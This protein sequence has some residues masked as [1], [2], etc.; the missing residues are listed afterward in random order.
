MNNLVT[1]VDFSKEIGLLKTDFVKEM[2]E[3]KTEF[4]RSNANLSW[5]LAGFII[6]QM[7]VFLVIVK[8]LF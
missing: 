5:K 3:L 6:A 7:G 2:S 1:K 8:L 4:H